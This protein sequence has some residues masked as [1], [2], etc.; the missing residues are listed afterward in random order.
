MGFP[1]NFQD[2]DKGIFVKEVPFRVAQR[3]LDE[4][5]PQEALEQ[6]LSSIR[7]DI[8]VLVEEV[9]PP[10]E[11]IELLGVASGG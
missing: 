6:L 10:V 7:Y 3:L 4:D 2:F 9:I 5:K 1:I 8:P 11:V